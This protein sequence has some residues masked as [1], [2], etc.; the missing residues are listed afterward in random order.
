MK[1]IFKFNFLKIITKTRFFNVTPY[2][3][4]TTVNTGN[5]SSTEYNTTSSYK[6]NMSITQIKTTDEMKKFYYMNNKQMTFDTNQLFNMLAHY[7][8]LSNTAYM[9]DMLSQSFPTEIIDKISQDMNSLTP[10]SVRDLLSILVNNVK[11]HKK[12]NVLF[13]LVWQV[14]KKYDFDT[15]FKNLQSSSQLKDSLSCLTIISKVITKDDSEYLNFLNFTIQLYS[16]YKFTKLKFISSSD[17]LTILLS[18]TKLDVRLIDLYH[19]VADELYIKFKHLNIKQMLTILWVSSK[20]NLFNIRL[21]NQILEKINEKEDEFKAELKLLEPSY[22]LSIVKFLTNDNIVNNSVSGL[23]MKKYSEVI[24]K[25]LE[26]VI[27]YCYND[28]E[29]LNVNDL[30]S[31]LKF[32][33]LYSGNDNEKKLRKQILDK[34]KANIKEV[35]PSNYINIL[36]IL[37]SSKIKLSKEEIEEMKNI[38]NNLTEIIQKDL[39]TNSKTLSY[40]EYINICYVYFRVYNH[41]QD[42]ID[43]N[44]LFFISLLNELTLSNICKNHFETIEFLEL[45]SYIKKKDEKVYNNIRQHTEKEFD[46][47]NLV[48]VK[49]DKKSLSMARVNLL[50]LISVLNIDIQ[51]ELQEKLIKSLKDVIYEPQLNLHFYQKVIINNLIYHF[52]FES[53]SLSIN[54]I[55]KNAMSYDKIKDKIMRGLKN[56]DSGLLLEK[57][58]L[59]RGVN[60][61][62]IYISSKKLAFNFVLNT[63]SLELSLDDDNVISNH[64]VNI[65]QRKYYEE[66]GIKLIS[67]TDKI[68]HLNIKEVEGIIKNKL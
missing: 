60:Y 18:S 52:K 9:K 62:D 64:L 6:P 36:S 24:N 31:I 66:R 17:L 61:A 40:R 1:N 67:V 68:L 5:T 49:N 45:L 26:D 43:S 15:Y 4:F 25:S 3:K 57:D 58:K 14:F 19:D 34:I 35:K 32:C 30:T 63:N 48:I 39:E 41:N 28:K 11:F 55:E 46:F 22:L 50:Y 27:D 56:I 7:I 33:Y 38:V 23:G 59:F 20:L 44:N 8:K 29:S 37:Y 16:K 65:Y 12:D 47:N 53:R 10:Y 21:I 54:N 42:M 13:Q 2:Y 51:K